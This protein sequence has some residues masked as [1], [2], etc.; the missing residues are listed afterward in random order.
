MMF[1]DLIYG[2]IF[3]GYLLISKLGWKG[4]IYVNNY[5]VCCLDVLSILICYENFE[6]KGVVYLLV[7]IVVRIFLKFFVLVVC[8]LV[9]FK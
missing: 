6:G 8:I 1:I 2:W 3:Y 4:L 7:F 5:I 9:I